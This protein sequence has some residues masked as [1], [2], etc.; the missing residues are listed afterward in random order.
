MAAVK[1][2]VFVYRDRILSYSETFILNQA[3]ALHRFAPVFVGRQRV[4]GLALDGQEVVVAGRSGLLGGADGLAQFVGRPRARFLTRLAGLA[5]ALIH[6]HFGRD[7]VS[8][9]PLKDRLRVPLIVTFHGYDATQR[10][11]W[12][13]GPLAWNY[14][15]RRP[16]LA[17]RADRVIAVSDHIHARLLDL[18]FPPE[19]V[20]THRIGVDL[21]CFAPEPASSERRPVVLAVGRFVEKKGFG[22]L[23][24]AM[25]AVQAR[26]PDSELV[27]IGDGPLRRDLERQAARLLRRACFTGPCPPEQVTEWMRR[28]AVLAV[29]SVT[30]ASGDT[31]GLPRSSS[32]DLRPGSRPSGP[33]TPGSPRR[34]GTANLAISCLS[35]TA[36]PWPTASSSCSRTRAGGAR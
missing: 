19:R 25:A 26:R 14:G 5:P 10:V 2:A 12:R 23:I 31:E 18:G 9:L 1:P 11:G 4:P 3:R 24:E 6:A 29:P 8:A 17:E 13:E 22:Y 28:A 30:S 32:R 34:S 27:L 36:A 20:T 35:A 33:A 16:R 21:R 7:G 15:R